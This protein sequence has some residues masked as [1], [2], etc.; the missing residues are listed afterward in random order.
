MKLRSVCWLF[1]ACA[2]ISCCVSCASFGD[3]VKR[4]Q[5]EPASNPDPVASQEG[6][7]PAQEY[8]QQKQQ[9][10]QENGGDK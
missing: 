4:N 9:K 3:A 7:Y 1:M 6:G 2:L 5:K 10:Q 8:E